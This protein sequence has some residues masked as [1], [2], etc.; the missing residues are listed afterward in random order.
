MM[1]TS[2]QGGRLWLWLGSP[3]AEGGYRGGARRGGAGQGGA[4]R[5]RGS[6]DAEAPAGPLAQG[7]RVRHGDRRGNGDGRRG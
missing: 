5:L 7:G 3:G 2:F 4:E 1:E 6:Q